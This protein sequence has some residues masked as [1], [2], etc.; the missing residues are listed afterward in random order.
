MDIDNGITYC[1]SCHFASTAKQNKK[2]LTVA[3]NKWKRLVEE[4]VAD[5]G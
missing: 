1:R 2:P 4:L 5:V 3:E